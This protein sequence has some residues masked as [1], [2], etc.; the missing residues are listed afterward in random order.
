[1]RLILTVHNNQ[2]R[3]RLTSSGDWFK[4]LLT[5]SGQGVAASM[6]ALFLITPPPS[7]PSRVLF[8]F[9]KPPHVALQAGSSLD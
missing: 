9:P 7:I 6:R 8:F 1:M 3:T 4:T 2:T 5:F